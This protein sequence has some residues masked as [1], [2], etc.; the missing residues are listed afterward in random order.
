MNEPRA[1]DHAWLGYD[2][3]RCVHAAIETASCRA[4]VDVCPRDAW[5][6]D[7]AALE[8]HGG[9]CDGCGLCVPACPRRAITATPRF[10]RTEVAGSAV[11]VVACDR[12]SATSGAGRPGCLHAISLT[13]LL[14][15]YAEGYGVWLVTR[16]DCAACPR[17]SAE[18]LFSRLAHLNVMLRQRGKRPILL[19]EVSLQVSSSL[20]SGA[21][22]AAS[23]RGFIRTLSRRPLAML[24]DPLADIDSSA[25]QPPGE[26]LPDGDDAMMPWVV[27][28]DPMRCIGCH[29]C[30]RVC[31]EGAIRFD[32]AVPAYH[33]RHRA[34]SGC[35]LCVDV[36]EAG[37]LELRA[38]AEP[39]LSGVAL[40]EKRCRSCG[41]TF[42]TP[43]A[44]HDA[45]AQCWICTHS[46]PSRRLYQVME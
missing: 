10:A 21:A 9:R 28:L 45:T 23:R 31:P 15:A 11:M 17:G 29:A 13:D 1:S 44:R 24:L 12:V 22:V 42:H 7:D 43:L 6:L 25:S 16:G 37:A 36:C 2:G 3:A 27:E 46:Q 35:G 14:R 40:S 34:C 33:L 8:F 5:H 30:A 41:V 20:I 26:Y 18:S 39:S 32:P 19:R 38:W 4:C